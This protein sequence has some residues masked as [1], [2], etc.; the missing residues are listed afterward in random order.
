VGGWEKPMAATVTCLT[1]NNGG[2]ITRDCSG[3][4]ARAPFTKLP[5]WREANKVQVSGDAVDLAC[6]KFLSEI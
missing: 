1:C 5:P 6:S 3:R 4:K 2:H